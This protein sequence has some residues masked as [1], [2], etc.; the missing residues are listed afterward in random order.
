MTPPSLPQ[1]LPAVQEISQ[2][3]ALA[4]G[5]SRRCGAAGLGATLWSLHWAVARSRWGGALGVGVWGFGV[6]LVAR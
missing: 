2:T 4:R 6:G 3:P 1:R 5:Q